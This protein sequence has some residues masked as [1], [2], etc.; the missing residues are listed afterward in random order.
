MSSSQYDSNES[1]NPQLT[2]TKRLLHEAIKDGRNKEAISII[3]EISS[4]PMESLLCTCLSY[5]TCYNNTVVTKH[6]IGMGLTLD[7]G[8]LENQL[9]TA[10][11]NNNFAI[12]ELLLNLSVNVNAT[13]QVGRTALM[14]A[15]CKDQYQIVTTLIEM[16]ADPNKRDLHGSN[17][18]HCLAAGQDCKRG[19]DI[20]DALLETKVEID[21]K[22]EGER[23]PLHCA[24]VGGRIYLCE[25]L[26]AL[27]KGRRANLQAKDAR[28]KT[29]L[30]FAATSGHDD[31]IDVLLKH[32]ADVHASADGS[33]KPIH[34]ACQ[35]GHKSTVQ[36]L[37]S[38]GAGLNS[39]LVNGMMPLH[40]ATRAGHFDVVKYLL[41][42]EHID[43][44]AKDSLGFTPFEHALQ[45]NREDIIEI[46]ANSYNNLNDDALGACHGYQATITDFGNCHNG[47]KIV[48]LSVYELLYQM[49]N[50]KPSKPALKIYPKDMDNVS[51]RWIHLPANNS[52][53][54][55]QVLR[56][57]LLEDSSQDSSSFVAAA[58][59]LDHH[60]DGQYTHSRFMRPLCQEMYLGL[61]TNTVPEAHGDDAH[62][63]SATADPR[64]T[65]S[66]SE[67]P[68]NLFTSMIFLYMPYLH[69]ESAKQYHEMHT[70]IKQAE[71]A[72]T[73][74]KR[75][76][77]LKRD[78][79]PRRPTCDE[80]LLNGYNSQKDLYIRRTLNQFLYPNVA[81]TSREPDQVVYKYQRN[82]GNAMYHDIDPKIFMVDQLWMWVLGEKL[83]ITAFPQRWQQPKNDP[84]DVFDAVI[85]GVNARART[86]NMPVRTVFDLALLITQ[87]CST[88]FR[89]RSG[90]HEYQLLDMF[91]QSIGIAVAKESRLFDDFNNASAEATQWL[92]FYHQQNQFS[93]ETAADDA[94]MEQE[95]APGLFF[96][97]LLEISAEIN[98]MNELRHIRK[99]LGIVA[100]IFEEQHNV[101]VNFESAVTKLYGRYQLRDV[102]REQI[103]SIDQQIKDLER[104]DKKT[105]RIYKSITELLDLKQKH[106]NALGVRFAR[107]Q[108]SELAGQRPTLVF[109]IVTIV[110]LPLS[111]VA[112]LFTV[113]IRELP[114]E[115]G[116]SE[117]SL[118]LSFVLK[119]L[120]GI[121]FGISIPLIVVVLSFNLIK[122]VVRKMKHRL[123]EFFT[124]E[125]SNSKA[126][127]VSYTRNDDRLE[128]ALDTESTSLR[129]R[130]GFR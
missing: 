69:Y 42:Q 111:F 100:S 54:V 90:F 57:A 41:Q 86:H 15:A 114:R 2:H 97:R 88:V 71:M 128:Q 27:P 60:Y 16:G 109:T 28:G 124:R 5:A 108:A 81:T 75:N 9:L 26:L 62:S 76:W 91:D 52:S 121:G 120:L 96:D 10:M 85:E 12:A 61:G 104:L 115:P 46:L 33:W 123:T 94:I 6:L 99:E 103:H 1:G 48:R 127:N 63:S 56:R 55:D 67:R 29:S 70:A 78:Q 37:L 3:S 92:H 39:K 72:K 19:R 11:E 21:A 102:F 40:I 116:D 84:L 7:G 32:G 106:A 20:I 23:T 38:A 122:D 18:L 43:P 130:R 58:R 53:W 119:Y 113:N 44:H 64:K 107:D 105:E 83:V 126:L 35:G 25:S 4:E 82:T 34:L 101:M 125:R 51:F 80:M 47:N 89:D 95:R 98:Q 66:R 14:N 93:H 49:D 45:T 79:S 118:P 31:V 59:S 117:P 73:T 65:E 87:Q 77:S 36:K 129:S 13:N 50:A 74:G 30:H 68:P 8:D 110:F 24:A 22:D 17:V 112:T